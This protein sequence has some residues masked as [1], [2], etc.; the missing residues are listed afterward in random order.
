M[1]YPKTN[2]WF[3]KNNLSGKK[4]RARILFE[5]NT[6]VVQY[7]SPMVGN[8]FLNLLLWKS[9]LTKPGT[10]GDQPKPITIRLNSDFSVSLGN[11]CWLCCRWPG[12][13]LMPTMVPDNQLMTPMTTDFTYNTKESGNSWAKAV[14]PTNIFCIFWY[15][16]QSLQLFEGWQHWIP[17]LPSR[18]HGSPLGKHQPLSVKHW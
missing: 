14:L 2:I 3:K 12:I 1:I 18:K 9:T 10:L 17:R 4:I 8:F 6:L 7:N 13:P 16:H 11:R 15:F 5:N